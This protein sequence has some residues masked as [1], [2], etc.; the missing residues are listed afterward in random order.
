M[1]LRV[2]ARDV[3]TVTS[4]VAS[5]RI[6]NLTRYFTRERYYLRIDSAVICST[7]GVYCKLDTTQVNQKSESRDKSDST[8]CAVRFPPIVRQRIHE[9]GPRSSKRRPQS[10]ESLIALHPRP[11]SSRPTSLACQ[12]GGC[13]G[14]KFTAGG[15]DGLAGGRKA[16]AGRSVFTV[17]GGVLL[18]VAVAV[19]KLKSMRGIRMARC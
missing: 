17:I 16:N 14:G 12:H 18:S 11:A 15:K 7:A 8:V 13:G 10:S 2:V 3:D 4:S 6:P 1:F 9:Q 19:W 5:S